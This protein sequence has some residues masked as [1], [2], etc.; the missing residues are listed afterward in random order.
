[1]DCRSNKSL[2]IKINALSQ[3]HVRSNQ[4]VRHPYPASNLLFRRPYKFKFD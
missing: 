2:H 4:I 1:M 3:T